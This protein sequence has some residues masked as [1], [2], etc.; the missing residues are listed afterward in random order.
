MRVIVT[1]LRL[2]CC[3]YAKSETLSQ[4]A[5]QDARPGLGLAA[6]QNQACQSMKTVV[7][8]FPTLH[9]AHSIEE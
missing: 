2:Q 1:M 3:E 8:S 5:R 7:A 4:L 9:A 6:H